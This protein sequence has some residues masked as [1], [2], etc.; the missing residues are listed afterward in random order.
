M[1]PRA[2]LA[3]L[4]PRAMERLRFR[5]LREFSVLPL[6]RQGRKMTDEQCLLYAAHM[7]LSRAGGLSSQ[8]EG[9]N[10][11]FDRMRFDELRR[12]KNAKSD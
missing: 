10:P 9:T 4:E 5:V 2:L 8:P 6:S 7:I 1:T 12:G 3:A 11:G